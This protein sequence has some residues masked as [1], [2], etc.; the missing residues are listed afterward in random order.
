MKSILLA[1]IIACLQILA[2]A[3]HAQTVTPIG[4]SNLFCLR[5]PDGVT[6]LA[7][8]NSEG[9]A[10]VTEAA[11]LKDISRRIAGKKTQRAHLAAA[12]SGASGRARRKISNRISTVKSQ[13]AALKLDKSKI[14]GCLHGLA[15]PTSF[16]PLKIA[17]KQISAQRWA[18]WAYIDPR[19]TRVSLPSG[20]FMQYGSY[21]SLW[22]VIYYGMFT[23]GTRPAWPAGTEKSLYK[24]LDL[25][26]PALHAMPAACKDI[27]G[28]NN[29]GIPLVLEQA[30]SD[31]EARAAVSAFIGS[32]AFSARIQGSSSCAED[33]SL[34]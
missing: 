28:R 4:E 30:D 21:G 22:C 11:S 29:A 27:Y 34:L 12:L 2:S 9:Y 3:S 6:K 14:S 5:A 23:N 26:D 13:I 1:G 19:P 7:Q 32:I 16:L 10:L 8:F 24:D 25:C 15:L 31:E 17:S 18:A 33:L 20:G